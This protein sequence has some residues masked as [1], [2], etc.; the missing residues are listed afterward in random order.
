MQTIWNIHEEVYLT[1]DTEKL[2]SVN[3]VKYSWPGIF[4]MWHSTQVA[5]LLAEVI[6]IGIK[7]N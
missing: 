7:M 5:T 2:T 3:N 6:I 1:C 4:I